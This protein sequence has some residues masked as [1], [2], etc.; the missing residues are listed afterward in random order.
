MYW[1]EFF[2]IVIAHL[3]AV[4]SP[5]PDF[6]VV[7]RQSVRCGT[8]SGIWTSLGVGSAI[9]LHVAYCLLGV[10]FLLSQSTALFN[11]MK[12]LAAVYLF[13]LGVQSIRASLVQPVIEGEATLEPALSAV[14][15]FGLGFVTN[16]LNPKATLFF[17]AL[18]TVVIDPN[19]P[20]TIQMVYG[21]YLA[22]ATFLWF[23][24]LSLIL[25]IPRV[26]VFILRMGSWLE[27]AMG[28]ILI[29]ISLQLA[30]NGV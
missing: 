12:L 26:R 13:Y 22:G 28:A 21:L 11:A 23:A 10:A 8:R 4:T 17:L 15:A 3:F 25:G 6:A 2:T 7:M 19:T 27:R 16:G 9:L 1:A 5:G 18:F 24:F 20:T 30:L 14:R 29:L